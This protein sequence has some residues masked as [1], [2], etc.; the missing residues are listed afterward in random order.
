MHA[1][2]ATPAD[3]FLLGRQRL[4]QSLV[5]L[6]ARDAQ[7]AGARVLLA[8]FCDQLVDYL[9]YGH[10]RALTAAPPGRPEYAAIAATTATA[11]AFADRFGNLAAPD[12]ETARE[13]LNAL[14]L[15]LATRFELEDD[16]LRAWPP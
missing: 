6:A 4:L 1:A 7:P 15:T 14:A 12:W 10:F 8:R 16:L 13:E 2:Q 11:M 9:S 5:V 3:R